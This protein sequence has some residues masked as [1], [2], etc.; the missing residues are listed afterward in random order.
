MPD[1]LSEAVHIN[2]LAGLFHALGN[3]SR[4]RML[5]M[6]A[7]AGGLR[8]MD[9]VDRMTLNQA[10]VSYHLRVL[11]DAG[12]ISRLTRTSPYCLTPRALAMEV[13]L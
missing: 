8:V 11:A 10:T 9:L 12:L 4:L 5:T 2:E 3:S 1:L 13:S 7:A 6:I